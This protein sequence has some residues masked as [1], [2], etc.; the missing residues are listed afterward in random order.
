MSYSLLTMYFIPVN[1]LFS[2]IM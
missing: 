2:V 1:R